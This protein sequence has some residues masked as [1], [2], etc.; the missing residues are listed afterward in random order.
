MKSVFHFWNIF[1]TAGEQEKLL[2][3]QVCECFKLYSCVIGI[4]NTALPF[5]NK[6]ISE[7]SDSI[8]GNFS[9]KIMGRLIWL[10]GCH[11][12]LENEQTQNF[13]KQL[14]SEYNVEDI[15][16]TSASEANL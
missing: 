15:I 13:R 1:V 16:A 2:N 10:G 8:I 6:H 12:Q 11:D 3:S 4:D 7:N 9:L 5:T 14:L